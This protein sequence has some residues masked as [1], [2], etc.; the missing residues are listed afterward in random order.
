MHA[1]ANVV[2]LFAYWREPLRQLLGTNPR[3]RRLAALPAQL[4]DAV[5]GDPSIDDLRAAAK[6]G[7]LTK[8]F[9]IN[10][11]QLLRDDPVR[12]TLEIRIMPGAIDADVI[13]DRSAMVERLLDRC[14]DPEPFPIPPD[15]PDRAV[16]ALR[17]LAAAER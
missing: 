15:D 12:D 14:R 11:T 2:R 13:I 5:A 3:C 16:E 17:V 6:E 7:G 8:F 10:L 1:L 4:V 9:D